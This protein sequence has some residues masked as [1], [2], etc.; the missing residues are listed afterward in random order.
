MPR[1]L[2]NVSPARPVPIATVGTGFFYGE[3]EMI[4]E[5]RIVYRYRGR[6]FWLRSYWD[7]QPIGPD[8]AFEDLRRFEEKIVS[9]DGYFQRFQALSTITMR[10]QKF[11]MQI[12]APSVSG[13]R[14][15]SVHAFNAT[16]ALI[17]GTQPWNA[18]C[19]IH[20]QSE[21]PGHHAH[22]IQFG[23][24]PNFNPPFGP[25]E[26]EYVALVERWMAVFVDGF[27]TTD[28]TVWRG[29]IKQRPSSFYPCVGVNVKLFSG[30]RLKRQRPIATFK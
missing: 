13:K 10:V 2:Y 1:S 25:T 5:L 29:V 20:L 30:V 15:I 7:G 18:P 8:N 6:D 17:T 23:P 26:L 19:L 24:T 28:G 22:W 3:L 27:T 16:G 12:I 21:S 11:T 9:I 4:L 14:D